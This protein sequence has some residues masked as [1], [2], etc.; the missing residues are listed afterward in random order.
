MI[1]R[2]GYPSFIVSLAFILACTLLALCANPTPAVSQPLSVRE[3]NG[4]ASHAKVEA[5]SLAYQT[6]RQGRPDPLPQKPVQPINAAAF[7][8]EVRFIPHASPASHA[9]ETIAVHSAPPYPTAGQTTVWRVKP[10]DC[11]WK[12]ALAKHTTV[13]AIVQENRLTSTVLQIGQVLH[14]IDGFASRRAHDPKSSKANSSP[15]KSWHPMTYVVQPGDSLW[16]ISHEFGVSIRAIINDNALLGDDI[17]PGQHLVIGPMDA[18]PPYR[19]QP[20]LDRQ[21]TKM[22]HSHLPS[23]GSQI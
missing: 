21:C 8:R 10:G 1:R 11:L 12:I 2:R 16:K 5:S 7:V 23:G 13:S 14:I 9:R 4:R 17:Q 3:P 20:R 15:T 6:T 22:A 18:L 19:G